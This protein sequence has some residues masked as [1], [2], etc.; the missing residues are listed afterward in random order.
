[1][2]VIEYM[3]NGA[4]DSFLRVSWIYFTDVPLFLPSMGHLFVLLLFFLYN[5]PRHVMVSSRC[6]S[7]LA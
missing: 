4:L 3:E 5:H 1:M 7:W 6:S 2:I